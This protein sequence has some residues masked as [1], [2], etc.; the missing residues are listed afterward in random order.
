LEYGDNLHPDTPIRIPQAFWWQGPGG[1][2]VLHWLNEHYHTG[3]FL[4]LSGVQGFAAEKSRYF[5]E[6]DRMTVD[7]LYVVAQREIPRYVERLKRDDYAYDDL[8]ICTSGFFVD[9]SSPDDRWCSLIARWNSEHDD[10][11]LRTSTMS[12]WF[13]KLSTYDTSNLPTYQVAWPDHWAHGL[14]SMSS[15]IAQARRIQRNRNQIKT[16]VEESGSSYA[17]DHLLAARDQ[18]LFALEHTFNA[19]MTT[20]IPHAEAISFLQTAKELDFHRAELNYHEAASAA[21]RVLVSRSTD[22]LYLYVPFEGANSSFRTVEF[23]GADL[24]LDADQQGLLADDGQVYPFQRDSHAQDRARYIAIVPASGNNKLARFQLVQHAPDAQPQAGAA[25]EL[26]T[27][28]WHLRVDPVSA[29]LLSLREKANGREWVGD[30][31][32]YRFG[33]LVHE[34]VIHP[35]GRRAVGNMARIIALG[36]AAEPMLKR[37][38]DAPIFERITPTLDTAPLHQ[39]GSVF[40][41]VHLGGV[42]GNL[43]RVEITWRLYHCLPLV[44]LVLDWDKE[45]NRQ[46]EA[47]Y[48]AF[49][50]AHEGARLLLEAPGAFFQPGSH[51]AGGQLAGTCSSYYTIQRAAHLQGA[52]EASLLWLP[53]DAPLVMTQEINYNRWETGPWEWNGFLASMPINH[54]WHTNFASSQRGY[55]R[56]RYRMFSP[57]SAPDLET[58][59][60]AA[61]PIEAVGW[62]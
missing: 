6:S 33:Q 47:T 5:W 11:Q 24:D 44:E 8:I 51:T 29:G 58:A 19:W 25:T 23:S 59:I 21:L 18:E 31:P 17:A 22:Q 15:R 3:N 61:Q 7:D 41:S 27:A 60:R 42:I 52:N 54:Y 38:I 1:K 12:E 32:P 46:P 9:N 40:D 20:A 50:F 16:L 14:G 48:I 30:Q 53:L 35:L 4:G 10:I 49:P 56:F 26:H 43:G 2:K 37:W 55:M 57:D 13:D 36:V 34:T 28:A 45:W 39:P 62:R